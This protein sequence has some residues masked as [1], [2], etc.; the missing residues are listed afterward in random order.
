MNKFLIILTI[1]LFQTMAFAQTLTLDIP[2]IDGEQG[3]I[4]EVPITVVG[5]DSVISLQFSFNWNTD[6]A[7]Y[8]DYTMDNLDDAAIGENESNDG[9]LR[10]SWFDAD[11]DGISLP[12]GATLMTLRF[13]AVGEI[14]EQ[15]PVEITD[16]PLAIQAFYTNNGNYEPTTLIGNT[17]AVTIIEPV[18]VSVSAQTGNIPCFG[19]TEGFI[20]LN[21]MTNGN[22]Y[23]VNWTGPNGFTSEDEDISNLPGGNYDLTVLDTDGNVVLDSTFTIM[24]PLSALAVDALDTTVSNCGEPDGSASISIIGGT[25]PYTYDIG[26]GITGQSDFQNLAPDT[27]SIEIIDANQCELTSSFTIES[28][29]LPQPAIDSVIVFCE[30]ELAVISAGQFVEYQWSTGETSDFIEVATAGDY[31]VTVTN[32]F[33]CTAS[34]STT[35]EVQEQVALVLENDVLEICPGESIQLLI[36][37]GDQYE[38]IDTTGAFSSLTVADPI[39]TPERTELYYA[40]GSNNCGSDT[41][42]VEILL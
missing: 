38:W 22:N 9:I 36:S 10:F 5:F 26:N 24:E 15:T 31:A 39:V 30:G 8:S 37:G 35:T 7:E 3:Q 34:V 4:V 29:P 6:I 21:L 33:D 2:S 12:D 25:S 23:I 19:G 17:G 14:G 20:D 28:T 18:S 1:C 40:V 27:Y 11:G 16:T 32:E 42:P 41:I 13:L